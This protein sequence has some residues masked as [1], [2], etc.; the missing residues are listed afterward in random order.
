M[1]LPSCK[2][3]RTFA[4]VAAILPAAPS[5]AEAATYQF[6]FQGSTFGIDALIETDINDIVTSMTGTMTRGSQTLD[7]L[8]VVPASDPSQGRY[9]L[10]DNHFTM[11]APYVNWYGILWQTAGGGFANFYTDAGRNVLS[12]ANPSIGDFSSWQNLDSGS[13]IVSESIVSVA[14][15][16]LVQTPVPAA[17]WLFGSGILGLG[18]LSR[19]RKA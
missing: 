4:L 1:K 17:A 10:W 5:L 18:Y 15:F 12:Y 14:A 19:R 9:W 7:I 6:N 16:S 3:L 8:N 2:T 11:S 13:T